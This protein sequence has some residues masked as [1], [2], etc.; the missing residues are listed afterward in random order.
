MSVMILVVAMRSASD[1]LRSQHSPDWK[2]EPADKFRSAHPAFAFELNLQQQES[3]S[4]TGNQDA[5]I[6]DALDD[7]CFSRDTMDRQSTM[8][9]EFLAPNAQVCVRA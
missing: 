8:D 2:R 6:S 9:L 1:I 5:A 4:S 7:A 3:S